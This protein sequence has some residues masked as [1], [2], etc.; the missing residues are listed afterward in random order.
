M[1][2]MTLDENDGQRLPTATASRIRM[3]EDLPAALPK[4][5][6]DLREMITGEDL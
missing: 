5:P 3:L 2:G 4:I 6:A 1:S